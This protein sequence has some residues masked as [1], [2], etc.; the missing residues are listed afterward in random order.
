MVNQDYR[1]RTWARIAE[2]RIDDGLS[3]GRPALPS[4]YI[5]SHPSR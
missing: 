1:W 2:Q 5:T 4:D 3:G